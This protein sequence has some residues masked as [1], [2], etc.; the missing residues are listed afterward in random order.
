MAAK[1]SR[2]CRPVRI[3]QTD[4]VT[5]H[6]KPTDRVLDSLVFAPLGLISEAR[7]VIP[8][9]AEK[10]RVQVANARMMGQF[11]LQMG[12]AE[13]TKRVSGLEVQLREVL[14]GFGLVP[15]QIEDDTTGASPAVHDS[16]ARTDK[17]P[18]AE[19]V[20]DLL[21]Q[22][23]ADDLA[24]PDYDSLAA[25]HVVSRLAGLRPSELADVQ[26][27]ELQHRGRKTILGK[28]AQLQAS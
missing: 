16:H 15:P 6:K 26:R 9:L 7:S 4:A 12:S 5:D 8:Q 17:A 14:V 11:A 19:K 24:I 21:P 10:G 27:Y 18:A 3:G 28:I 1:V 25:S 22:P 23:T 20:A 2:L 13:A